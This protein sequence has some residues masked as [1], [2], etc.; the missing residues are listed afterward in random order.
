MSLKVQRDAWKWAPGLIVVVIV[1][2]GLNGIAVALDPCNGLQTSGIDYCTPPTYC[3][4]A[5]PGACQLAGTWDPYDC[6]Q[7]EIHPTRGRWKCISGGGAANHC[8]LN[9]TGVFCLQYY[10]CYYTNDNV[11]CRAGSAVC[12]YPGTLVQPATNLNDC[13]DGAM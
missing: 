6:Q 11:V 8:L 2:M 12:G 1:A 10:W 4:G 13:D 9:G 5:G 7:A 3:D